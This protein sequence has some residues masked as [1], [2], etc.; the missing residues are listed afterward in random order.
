M[1]SDISALIHA[2]DHALEEQGKTYFTPVEAN[3]ILAAM[4][5]LVDYDR[6]PGQ[7]IRRLLQARKFPHAYKLGGTRSQWVIPHSATR[8]ILDKPFREIPPHSS[9]IE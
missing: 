7:P 5:L 1:T 2:L 6:E 3:K 9:Q 4:G 8:R